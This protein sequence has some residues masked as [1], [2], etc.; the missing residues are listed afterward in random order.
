MNFYFPIFF[1]LKVYQQAP[2]AL[3]TRTRMCIV[4][5]F[6][7]RGKRVVESKSERNCA[8]II[9]PTDV[10]C[11]M[12]WKQIGPDMSGQNSEFLD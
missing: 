10:I 12:T 2:S 1:H 6:N 4:E 8:A 7:S 3:S 5:I 11:L 9:H